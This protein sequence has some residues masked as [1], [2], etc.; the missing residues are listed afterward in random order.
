MNLWKFLVFFSLFI[1]FSLFSSISAF[2]ILGPRVYY[3]MAADGKFFS[4]ASK[5][6][7]RFGVPAY[8]IIF[9]AII[10]I[11]IILSGTFDQILTYMGFSLGIFPILTVFGLFKLRRLKRSAIRMPGYP[12]VPVIFILAGVSMLLLSFLERPIES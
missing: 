8:S 6:H 7:P 5:I 2:I 4:F 10:S 11:V 9:Q 12:L 3:A 1:S